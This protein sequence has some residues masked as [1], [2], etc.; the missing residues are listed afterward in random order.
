MFLAEL[1]IACGRKRKGEKPAWL[2]PLTTM[3]RTYM[4]LLI[5][6]HGEDVKAMARD[7]K[8]NKMQHSVSVLEQLCQR[9]HAFSAGKRPLLQ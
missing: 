5:K 6:A 3:Q 2:V 4:D 8:L 7:I 9:Y 1:K